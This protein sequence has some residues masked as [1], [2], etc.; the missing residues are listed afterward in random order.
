MRRT[1][2]LLLL[3]VLAFCLPASAEMAES[4]KREFHKMEELGVGI[5]TNSSLRELDR[6]MKDPDLKVLVLQVEPP[7]LTEEQAARI[8]DWVRA[9]H[10]LWFYDARLA[11]FFGMKPFPLRAEQFKGKPEDGT[12]G[13]KVWEGLAT[14]G[15]ATGPHE[16]L[17]GV[18]QCTIFLPE[19]EEDTFGAVAVEGDT[20]PLLQF[21]PDSPALAALRR[22]GR[23]L[24]VFKPVLWTKPLSGERFQSNLLE[25][26]AGFGVPG[27]GGTERIGNPPGPEA[28][29][30]DGNPAV[31]PSGSGERVLATPLPKVSPTPG[32]SPAPVAAASPSPSAS[33]AP[34]P[35][36]KAT[37]SPSATR[38]DVFSDRVEV[39]GQG[40]LM[41]RVLNPS[42]RF[43]TSGESLR[44][45]RAE[46]ACLIVRAPS[47]L[48]RLETRD[49]RTLSGFLMDEELQV[50]MPE[51]LRT[52]GKREIVRV[53]FAPAP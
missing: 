43:E 36:P 52:F 7:A 6:L 31:T 46:V 3:A 24:V 37:P 12:I 44:V 18:G 21:S 8:M 49:G 20:L 16:V 30:V 39:T 11:P 22:D 14:T 17:S 35:S 4:L 1:V 23:G 25:F 19:L 15:L 48:D 50:Q 53:E 33:P 42:F 9:G 26:S 45:L 27:P 51:G 28:A 32:P 34:A 10:S 13:D 41:G 38:E 2:T 5:V 40:V 29:W 47:Q